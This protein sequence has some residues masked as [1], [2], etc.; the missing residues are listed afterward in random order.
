MSMICNFQSNSTLVRCYWCISIL[1]L[2]GLDVVPSVDW[3]GP[4][5][6]NR[7]RCEVKYTLDT[8]VFGNAS[9]KDHIWNVDL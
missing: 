4:G 9:W 5:Y 8:Q 3:L 2:F 1:L 6:S 7:I